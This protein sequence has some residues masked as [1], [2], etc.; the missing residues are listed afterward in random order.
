MLLVV[1]KTPIPEGQYISRM[2]EE[3]G[4]G[5]ATPAGMLAPAPHLAFIAFAAGAAVH[6]F[7]PAAVLPSPW[8]F[9]GATLILS[10][11]LRCW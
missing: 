8:N 5:S 2:T 9:V 10:R 6:Y 7:R 4:A 11:E 1:T 3:N